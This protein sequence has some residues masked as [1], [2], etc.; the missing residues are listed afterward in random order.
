MMTQYFD[1]NW[2]VLRSGCV[3][4]KAECELTLRRLQTGGCNSA[5][6]D[7]IC[8]LETVIGELD[9]RISEC[10]IALSKLTP[11]ADVQS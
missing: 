3:M 8:A 11:G 9:A 7:A 5:V 10:D 6:D 1:L 4:R 2:A